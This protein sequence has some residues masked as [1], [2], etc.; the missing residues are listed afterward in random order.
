V[1]TPILAILSTSVLNICHFFLLSISRYEAYDRVEGQAA[2]AERTAGL[3]N[4][5]DLSR[6]ERKELDAEK[7]HQLQMRHR[8][9]MQY[10]AARTGKWSKEGIKKRMGTV[11]AKILGGGGGEKERVQVESEA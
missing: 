3:A 8:G 10:Q 2:I 11:K 4:K 7:K 6:K 9:V 1:S 5:D